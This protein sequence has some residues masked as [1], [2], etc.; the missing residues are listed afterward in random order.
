VTI[1]DIKDLGKT[2]DALRTQ[3]VTM[4]AVVEGL[5]KTEGELAAML[6]ELEEADR[7]KSGHFQRFPRKEGAKSYES[8]GWTVEAVEADWTRVLR[9]FEAAVSRLVVYARAAK[10][11]TTAEVA[12]SAA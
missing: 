3:F 10:G 4:H 2:L 6:A 9:R 5:P 7:D 8:D 1:V 12:A 11:T